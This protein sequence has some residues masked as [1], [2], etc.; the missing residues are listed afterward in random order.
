MTDFAQAAA[1]VDLCK[2]FLALHLTSTAA[3]MVISLGYNRIS[4]MQG[5]NDQNKEQ[6]LHLFWI[7]YIFDTSFSVRLGRS[8]VLRANDIAV[9]Q[10]ADN[11]T[12]ARDVAHILRYWSNLGNIQCQVVE[13]LYTKSAWQVSAEDRCKR[14]AELSV[15]LQK[16]W[17]ARSQVSL[18]DVLKGDPT[19][20]LALVHQSDAIIHFSTL[21]LIQHAADT[22][23]NMNSPALY[24]ARQALWHS[25]DVRMNNKGMPESVW[26]SHCHWTLLNAP[27]TPVTVV[28]CH[29]IADPANSESDLHLLRNFTTNLKSLSH[30]SEGVKNLHLYCD[31]FLNCA[32]LYSQ[33]RAQSTGVA[34]QHIEAPSLGQLS[35]QPRFSEANEYLQHAVGSM[36][37]DQHSDVQSW[38]RDEPA[39]AIWLDDWFHGNSMLVGPSGGYGLS[40]NERLKEEHRSH[41]DTV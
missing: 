4:S 20:S 8:P 23:R 26:N 5:D 35:A 15:Q 40:Y 31:A 16:I 38:A 25:I 34:L 19:S 28:F 10:L 13:H 17:E 6:K 2:P 37:S 22:T 14:A 36:R 12:I 30:L 24:A 11:G 39:N 27:F 29:I 1:A 7:V 41:T 32:E 21:A 18:N 33:D 3:S 9:P